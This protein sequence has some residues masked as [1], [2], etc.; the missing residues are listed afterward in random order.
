MFFRLETDTNKRKSRGLAMETGKLG[1]GKWALEWWIVADGCRLISSLRE[2]SSKLRTGVSIRPAIHL[3]IFLYQSIP[4]YLYRHMYMYMHIY[5]CMSH[6][7]TSQ[8][9]PYP[10]RNSDV[11]ETAKSSQT[12][13]PFPLR[14][15]GRMFKQC[16]VYSSHCCQRNLFRLRLFE[17]RVNQIYNSLK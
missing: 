5:E 11:T 14:E 15:S 16:I 4:T 2:L 17:C 8:A 7:P 9:N 1:N 10:I 3:Y 12:A 13:I 6:P